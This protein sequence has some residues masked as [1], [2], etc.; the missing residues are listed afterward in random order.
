[1]RSGHDSADTSFA[2]GDGGVSDAGAED[3]FFEELAGEVHGEFAVADDDGSDGRFTGWCV[4][5]AGVES[6]QSQF[7]LPEAGVLP[8]I[9]DALGFLLK[10]F[11]CGDAGC[12]H[13]WWMRGRKQKRACAVVEEIDKIAAA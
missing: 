10:D 8:Q 12:G 4:H 5:A 9:L 6:E 3:A 11:E 7:S 2:F 13:R 1:M